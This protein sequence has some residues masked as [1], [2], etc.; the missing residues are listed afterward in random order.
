MPDDA[1]A[2]YGYQSFVFGIMDS[3]KISP[4]LN[5]SYGARYDLYA[6]HDNPALSPA[7][8][9][10]FANGAYVNGQYK[11]VGT[12]I[13]NIGGFG[14]FQPRFGF[15]WRPISRFT[16]RGGAGIFGGGTP[17]VYVSN[18]FSNTGVLTSSASISRAAAGG[19]SGFPGTVSAADQ[20]TI[21]NAAL[22]GVNGRTIPGAAEHLPGRNFGG[23]R[24]PTVNALDPDF[25]IPSQWRATLSADYR[26]NLGPLGDDWNFGADVLYSAVRNQVFF[27]DI[28]S[29]PVTV[30]ANALT[31]DGRHPLLQNMLDGATSTNTSTDILLTNTKKGRSYIGDRPLR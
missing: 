18:S 31:P 13:T 25:K 8:A 30:A 21:G 1:A 23:C 5:F 3:W 20:T 19:F 12:N 10:R 27:T 14:L 6:M 2:N 4:T 11:Q 24:R 17:D 15:D 16:L 22:N 28:R 29:A 7:Y 26:A 9:A